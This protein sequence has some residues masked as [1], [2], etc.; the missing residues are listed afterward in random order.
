[1]TPPR[2]RL[3]SKAVP[4]VCP[5]DTMCVMHTLHI[6]RTHALPALLS[7][8]VLGLTMTAPVALAEKPTWT[9]I[10]ELLVG[11]LGESDPVRM[12]DVMTRCTALTITLAGLAADFS[13]E[14]S[15]LYRRE[16]DRF[17]QN[18]VLI[19]TNMEK[20]LTGKDADIDNV[21]N[22]LV[23]E[24]KGMLTG[25]N[26]WLDDNNSTSG[27]YLNNEIELEMDSCHLAARL[28]EQMQAE[29]Q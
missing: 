27:S 16:A 12:S 26:D 20:E 9:P 4:S 24:V 10:A 2:I 5:T 28:A 13:P 14:M 3:P 25:Y 8:A 6:L 18:G 19:E 15:A 17:I 7:A 11:S 21:S 22:L 23:A 1:M 29:P